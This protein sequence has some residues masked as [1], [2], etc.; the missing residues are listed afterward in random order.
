MAEAHYLLTL[1]QRQRRRRVQLF[2]PSHGWRI[3]NQLVLRLDAGSRY[4]MPVELTGN[5]LME[6]KMDLLRP[7]VEVRMLYSTAHR[8]QRPMLIWFRL[9][10]IFQD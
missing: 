8:L 1:F 7:T 2:L 3:S 10:L 6:I 5:I 9:F 4:Q